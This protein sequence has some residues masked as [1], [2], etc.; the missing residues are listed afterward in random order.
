MR[1]ILVG[2][3]NVLAKERLSERRT[4][5]EWVGLKGGRIEG[6]WHLPC[7]AHSFVCLARDCHM[8]IITSLCCYHALLVSF[9]SV[10]RSRIVHP[11]GVSCALDADTQQ[12]HRRSL[13]GKAMSWHHMQSKCLPSVS[14]S[15]PLVSSRRKLFFKPSTVR[16]LS[17]ISPP[18]P[19]HPK[20]L[21]P[22]CA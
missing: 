19:H 3:K 11:R 4:S 20:Q 6:E 7:L 17:P 12:R 5:S 16:S 9:S 15:I 10:S 21:V 22:P 13:S 2:R 18:R 1:V 8:L 14:V